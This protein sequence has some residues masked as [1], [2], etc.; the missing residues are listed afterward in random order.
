M[1]RSF[2][3]LFLLAG[4]LLA[5]PSWGRSQEAEELLLPGQSLDRSMAAGEKHAYRVEVTDAPLLVTVEQQ[6]IDLVLEVWGPVDEELRTGLGGARWGPE[7]LLLESAGER[8]IEVRPKEKSIW[9][10]RYTIRVEPLAKAS[11]E[12]NARQQALVLMSRAG[13]EGFAGTPETRQQAATTCREALAAWQAVGDRRWEAEALTCLATLEYASR[14]LR[15]AIED[16]ER[17][18][19]IWQELGE[20][21]REA[22]TLNE[23]GVA[24]LDTGEIQSARDALVRSLSLWTSLAERFDA[25]ETRSNLCFLEQKA[26]DLS[27]ALTCYDEPRT[28]FREA[29][30]Q[31]E[32]RRIANNLGGI[33]DLLGEPD[34][35][36]DHYQQSLALS[37]ALGDD[38]FEARTLNNIALIHRILGQWQE[39][40]RLYGQSREI[41]ERLGDRSLKASVL[42]NVGI[43]YNSLGEPQ[44]ALTF[45]EESLGLRREIGDRRGEAITL[46][47]LG[48]IWRGLGDLEKARG[49]FRQGLELA[50]AVK[51]ARQEAF[52]RIGLADVLIESRDPLGALREL[53]PALAYLKQAGLRSPETQALQHKGRALTLAG[54]SS[55]ALTILQDVVERQRALRNRAG[56][57]GAL[58]ALAL[59]ERSLG[60]HQEART[61]AEAAIAR[62]EELRTGFFSPDLRSS[63]LATQRR[64]YSLLIDLLMDRHA[65]EPAGGWDRA[66]LAVSE[67]ARARTLLDALYSDS[68]RRDS[69]VPAELLE[70]RQSLRRRLSAKTDQQVKSSKAEALGKEIETLLAELDRVYAEIA[71]ADPQAAAFRQPQPIELKEMTGLLDPG[72]LLL[73]YALGEEKSYLWMVGPE[74][75]R[76]FV[77]PPQREIEELARRHLE[78]VSTVRAGAAPEKDAADSLGTLL[79]GKAWSEASRAS[80]LVIVPDGALHYVPFAALRVPGSSREYLLEHAEVVYLPS[81]TTLAL[82][83]KR[84]NHRLPASKWA[85]ILADPVFAAS[86]TRLPAARRGPPAGGKAGAL[87]ER[88]PASGREAEEIAG[89]APPGQVWPAIGFEA[90][91]EAV[92]SGKLGDY[93]VV[94]FATHGVADTHNPERSGL[95]LS[96]V[97]ASGGSREGFLGLSDIYE[98]DLRADL[99][100]LSGCRTGLGKEV[101]GEGLMS[102]T[103]AF[104]YA[105]VPRVVASLWQVQDRA[106]AELMSR[107]YRAMW[108]DGLP[109]SAALRKAQRQLRSDPRYRSSYSWAGFVLQGDWK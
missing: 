7:V 91:R 65:A 93:R 24:R 57:A 12:E 97:D 67:Q 10:G 50:L 99:V 38:L 84:L 22:V 78:E 19:A 87:W 43:T 95:V 100:V 103:R 1:R 52:T 30:V 48:N 23:L 71:R 107:F 55:E 3:A 54:R 39:A 44:R 98:L 83:R 14:E 106:T 15:P 82:S 68:E 94:H 17:A 79:L 92:L 18:L 35:A 13:Q 105:G 74:G 31:S 28:V 41:V 34:F 66:A 51:D 101:R 45:V 61:H 109:P 62:V 9:P 80:R 16:H 8:R 11:T 73:E 108:V 5:F 96:L 21:R 102:L 27:A 42:A 37:R 88:L 60:L 69:A 81:A 20:T 70:R 26:G 104:L 53:D 89:L 90:S 64:A 86:D 85:A 36:L 77:L 40:L 29:E 49:Y 6:S 32:E 59:A 75:L 56:E 2:A 63:F 76:S 25:A 47:H 4:S 33:Y 58:H 46:N 72:T